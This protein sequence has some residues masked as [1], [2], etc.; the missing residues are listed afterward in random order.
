MSSW[1]SLFL[2]RQ[3]LTVYTLTANVRG[4]IMMGQCIKET[5]ELLNR[6]YLKATASNKQTTRYRTALERVA[7]MTRLCDSAW[8]KMVYEICTEALDNFE[9]GDM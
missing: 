3:V 4:V 6:L 9:R 7:A 5:K 2:E 8:E 1:S